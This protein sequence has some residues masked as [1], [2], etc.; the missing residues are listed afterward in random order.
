MSYTAFLQ[1][2]T[3]KQTFELTVDNNSP[4]TWIPS[5]EC[6]TPG[7]SGKMVYEH[8]KSSTYSQNGSSV[9]MD[10]P[11]GQVKGYL[12]EDSAQFLNTNLKP[13]VFR[14]VEATDLAFWF[15]RV[16][17]DGVLGLGW[18]TSEN[19]AKDQK[20]ATS[21][22]NE[23]Y[24]QG[25]LTENSFSVFLNNESNKDG[26]QLILGG[27]DQRYFEG[28]LDNHQIADEKKWNL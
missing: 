4:I 22:I 20:Q 15:N 24:R 27:Y 11:I 12:S 2:G 7:C 17:A 3:P 28:K 21:I 6:M 9:S 16:P 19:S 18:E 1:I 13:A 25:L 5:A 8:D 10:Y 26:S 23:F 14:F